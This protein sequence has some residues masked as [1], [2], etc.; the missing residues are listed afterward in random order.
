[1]RDHHHKSMDMPDID[2]D[3]ER[4]RFLTQEMERFRNSNHT[5][6]SL[7]RAEEQARTGHHANGRDSIAYWLGRAERAWIAVHV[8]E[9]KGDKKHSETYSL[10]DFAKAIGSTYKEVT[11]LE[12]LHWYHEKVLAEYDIRQQKALNTRRARWTNPTWNTVLGWFEKKPPREPRERSELDSLRARV[13]ELEVENA[14]LKARLGTVE[15]QSEPKPQKAAPKPA[16]K[17]EPPKP[18]PP[19]PEPAKPSALWI[20]PQPV[21]SKADEYAEGIWAR[22]EALEDQIRHTEAWR[23]QIRQTE[24]W[25]DLFEAEQAARL[26]MSARLQRER[27]PLYAAVQNATKSQKAKATKALNDYFARAKAERESFEQKADARYQSRAILSKLGLTTM[28]T[29]T[30]LTK[31]YH[32]AAKA[33]FARHGGRDTSPE[34]EAEFIALKAQFSTLRQVVPLEPEPEHDDNIYTPEALKAEIEPMKKRFGTRKV[35]TVRDYFELCQ[36]IFQRTHT[37]LYADFVKEATI[38]G[39][40]IGPEPQ[41]SRGEI[42]LFWSNAQP[43][44]HQTE[45]V[46][47]D[48]A[49]GT[50]ARA[51]ASYKRQRKQT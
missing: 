11:R 41:L 24:A 35:K 6:D 15:R 48:M 4:E 16:A 23:D 39:H 21:K 1:M 38:S 32:A 17:P 34:Y 18:E 20:V 12:K 42:A 43:H 25:S 44:L 40:S 5:V 14:S 7:T 27:E 8:L 22:I 13:A 26:A 30:E 29:P 10:A 3:A 36:A 50:L 2:T 28:P 19:K 33:L 31:H 47:F 37:S 45:A 49:D 51:Y 46:V 9:L